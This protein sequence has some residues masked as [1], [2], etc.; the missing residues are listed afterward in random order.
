M[1]STKLLAM[2]VVFLLSCVAIAADSDESK[3]VKSKD[4]CIQVT[5]PKGWDT[6]ELPVAETPKKW[7]DR[8]IAAETHDGDAVVITSEPQAESGFHSLKDFA[9][10]EV[11]R[12]K[13]DSSAFDE[14]V[15]T[16]ARNIK[17]DGQDA[18]QFGFHG[19]FK[20]G[21]NKGER[22]VVIVTSAETPTRWNLIRVTASQSRLDKVQDQIDA[23]NKSFKEL[24]K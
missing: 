8:L 14:T 1:K 4:K 24:S 9:D 10:A 21:V 20:N 19:T 13:R 3:T 23:I 6:I 15:F 17:V 5:L 22:L 7:Q 18:I 2:A 16:D 12:M 11:K